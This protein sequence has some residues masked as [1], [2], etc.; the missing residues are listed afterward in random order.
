MLAKSFVSDATDDNFQ[1]AV[2]QRSR[3]VPV[4]IDLWAT[5]CGPC[6]TLSPILEKLAIEYAG[7]FELVKVDVD[8]A[9]GIAQA[10]R[11]QSIPTVYL[12]V[13]GQ[14]I[15]GFQGAQTETAVRAMLDRHVES[16]ADPLDMADRAVA[17][18]HPAAAEQ[19]YRRILVEQPDEGRA[20]VGLARVLMSG[21][22]AAD[23][24]ALLERIGPN[25][26]LRGEAD[27]L[28]GVLGFA[29]DAGDLATLQKALDANPKDPAAWYAL[30]ATHAAG[31]AMDA[32]V[33]AFLRVVELDR[34]WREDAGRRA[35][36]SIFAMSNPDDPQVVTWR[37][38]LAAMLF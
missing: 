30:G 37:R 28:K 8:Q 7:A 18:G 13:D 6:K 14:P 34:S 2:L 26:P 19:I 24:G 3:T 27:K 15:D 29:A 38:R 25:D 4:L 12:I 11:V 32:A 5:W 31:G 9:P 21:G 1:E 17:E 10:F 36:L 35:L 33:T 20:I 23:A 22:R 16:A